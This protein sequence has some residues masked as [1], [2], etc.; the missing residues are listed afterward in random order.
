M[1]EKAT[2]A[3]LISGVV[4]VKELHDKIGLSYGRTQALLTEL[5]I[6]RIRGEFGTSKFISYDD[7]LLMKEFVAHSKKG[8]TIKEF[9]QTYTRTEK[10]NAVVPSTSSVVPSPSTP[11]EFFLAFSA[12]LDTIQKKPDVQVLRERLEVLVLA[13]KENLSLPNKD[14][15]SALGISPNTLRSRSETFTEYGFHFYKFKQGRETYWKVRKNED[16]TIIP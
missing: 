10:D 9:K 8:G 14:L 13:S 2:D 7:F 4:P 11:Q 15:A 16:E 6:P 5:E 12:A 3:E 1:P